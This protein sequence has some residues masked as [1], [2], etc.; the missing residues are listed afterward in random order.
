MIMVRSRSRLGRLV[1]VATATLGAVA[2]CSP[3]A[4]GAQAATGDYAVM[5]AT[6]HS[7]AKVTARWN[8]CQA[9]ITYRVNLGGVP[10]AKRTALLSDVKSSVQKL[11]AADG[12]TYRYTGTTSFV[13]KQGNL[14]SAPAEI[15]VAAVAPGATDFSLPK[16][17]LGFGGV[18]WSTWYGGGREGA[19]VVR[20]Y[21]VLSPAAM[22]S[23]KPGFGPGQT[24]GNVILHELGHASGL[25]HVDSTDELMN[26]VLTSS[27]PNGFGAGD[28][29]G[30]KKV[31]ARAGCIDIPSA[32]KV[33]DLS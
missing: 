19:A 17:A 31:G 30:L 26:P 27:A 9:A 16:N 13:P 28:R 5:K 4:T 3:F 23:L 32:V 1:S 12:M 33:A 25:D 22:T 29:T 15:V 6:L 21:V 7:G 24:R 20:G 2:L 14:T 10:A 8:P 18:I 11:A